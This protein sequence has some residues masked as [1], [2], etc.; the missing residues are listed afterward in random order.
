[1][2]LLQPL[3]ETVLLRAGLVTLPDTTDNRRLHRRCIDIFNND[4]GDLT[5]SPIEPVDS[6]SFVTIPDKLISEATLQHLGYR[7]EIAAH[8]WSR[9]VNWP[10]GEVI[11]ETDPDESGKLI[12]TFLDFAKGYAEGRGRQNDVTF[13]DTLEEWPAYLDACGINTETQTALMDPLYTNIRETGSCM[14]WILDTMELRYRG[15][16]LVQ[17]LSVKRERM[18][19]RA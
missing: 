17:T 15:L 6:D 5:S 2:S 18:I 7:S 19:Q 1:M 13:E 9:W 8:L 3:D 16:E 4:N 14:F 10:P 11:R 12:M